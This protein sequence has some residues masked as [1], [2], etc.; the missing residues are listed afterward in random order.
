VLL[1]RYKESDQ[2]IALA[3]GKALCTLFDLAIAQH[4]FE[5]A[6]QLWDVAKEVDEATKNDPYK[7]ALLRQVLSRDPQ[8]DNPEGVNRT[9]LNRLA[10][11]SRFLGQAY[12][13]C[14]PEVITFVAD[15]CSGN[16]ALERVLTSNIRREMRHFITDLELRHDW[17]T[18]EDPVSQAVPLRDLQHAQN[19]TRRLKES[20]SAATEPEAV[21]STVL[22]DAYLLVTLG[23]E[24]LRDRAIH[25]LAEI[26]ERDSGQKPKQ[27]IIAEIIKEAVKHTMKNPLAW[28][29][30]GKEEFPY[31][32]ERGFPDPKWFSEALPPS[33]LKKAEKNL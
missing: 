18:S 20:Y 28:I 19:E 26:E 2:L 32:R 17:L 15:L 29:N 33:L 11:Q 10:D 5:I 27:K 6:T 30:K 7:A 9:A 22:N 25:Q 8:W 3:G 31:D 12:C 16:T 21:L 24:A 1:G 4:D 14:L 23:V 13:R